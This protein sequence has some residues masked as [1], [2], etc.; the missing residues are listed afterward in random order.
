MDVSLIDDIEDEEIIDQELGSEE[1]I[2]TETTE[3]MTR[4]FFTEDSFFIVIY[5]EGDEL[6]DKLLVVS[7]LNID[8]DKTN[9]IQHD[10]VRYK[11]H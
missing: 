3:Q 11:A 4:D 1:V 7:D 10:R 8:Q 5:E 2:E 9:L 6:I